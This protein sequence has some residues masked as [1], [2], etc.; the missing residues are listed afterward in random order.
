MLTRYTS[1]NIFYSFHSQFAHSILRVHKHLTLLMH[2][3]TSIKRVLNVYLNSALILWIR[4]CW[5]WIFAG[6]NG[7]KQQLHSC[8]GNEDDEDD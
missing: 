3:K 5:V 2:E 7:A 1:M 6:E 4:H 8:D